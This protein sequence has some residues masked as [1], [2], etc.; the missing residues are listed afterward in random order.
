M[1]LAFVP[2]APT[3]RNQMGS[4]S[5]AA[6]AIALAATLGGCAVSEDQEVQIGQADAAQ[7]NAQLP[8]VSDPAINAYI[9]ALGDSIASKTSRSNL[10]WRF[11]VVDSK[12]INAFALP[13]G[14]IYVN[15]GL[16]EHAQRMDQLAGTMGHEIGHV[17]RRHSVEQMKK[18]QG[19]TIGVAL[20]CTLTRVCEHQG[21]QVAINV[22]GAAWFARHSR[23]DESE[24]DAEAVVNVVR[25]GIS[26]QGIPELFEILLAT[27]QT[28]PDR[29]SA[30]FASHPMEEQ[31]I[32]DT[33][34][35]I[36]DIPAA[37]LRGLAVD[38]PDFHA[39]K[40]RVEQLPPSPE[41]RPQDQLAPEQLHGQV[42][43]TRPR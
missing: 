17:V 41:P 27:R 18:A 15:R 8:L 6:L 22:G 38:S 9:N 10:Q 21:A 33:K 16:I 13:G 42:D 39:F 31:R 19:A 1:A 36:A 35:E 23:R 5:R 7:I 2:A 29:V 14:F 37:R 32:I 26:P 11:F 3:S 43:S 28:Q 4:R 34:R 12:D 30:F 24:A 25:A 40:R 20:L